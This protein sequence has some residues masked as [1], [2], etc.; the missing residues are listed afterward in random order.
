MDWSEF[1]NVSR[2]AVVSNAAHLQPEPPDVGGLRRSDVAHT[3]Q[4]WA[5]V[6]F[7][8]ATDQFNS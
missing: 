3:C 7:S 5:P 8:R 4:L 6:Q 2:P 1:S